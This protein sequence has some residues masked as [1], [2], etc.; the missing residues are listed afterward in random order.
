MLN[1]IKNINAKR[2]LIIVISTLFL[3]DIIILTSISFLRE[4]LPFLFFTIVPGILVIQIFRLNKLNFLKRSVLAV[5]TSVSLLIF[6]GLFLNCLYLILPEPLSLGP[7]L[8]SLNF[9][10]VIL[11]FLSY[12][13][14]KEDF[15]NF[16]LFNLDIK[17]KDKLVSPFIF[18][19]I[20]PFMAIFG[21]YLMNIANN[22]IILIAMLLLIP[23]Y[24]VVLIYLKDKI[25]DSV[26]PF[27]IFMIG[28]SLLLMR[29]LTSNHITGRDV[30]IE[31]YVFQ[32][33]LKNYY[34][35]L[36]AYNN[37]YNACLSITILPVI[38]KVLSNISSEYIFKL[39]F[40]LIGS[41]IPLSLYIIFQKYLDNRYAFC[42]SLLFV[43]QT[44]FILILDTVRQEIAF[45]F[46]FLAVWAFFGSDFN[47]SIK[48]AFFILFIISAMVSHYT[49]AYIA[50]VLIFPILLLPF[51]KSLF[52]VLKDGIKSKKDA[53][54]QRFVCF[55]NFDVIIIILILTAIWYIFAAKVQFEAGS[56]VIGSTVSSL[57]LNAGGSSIRN[58]AVLSILG[59]GI[60]S[61]P[62]FISVIVNNL[63]FVMIGIGLIF[64][65]KNYS[66]FKK[67]FGN[68]YLLGALISV[69]LLVL[70]VILPYVSNAYGPQRL[71]LQLAV[72]L[73]P[74][75][76]MG[77][78]KFA[79]LIKKP[80]YGIVIIL[81]L[82][83]SLFTCG[84][85]LQ[86]HF[87]G[88]PYSPFYEHNGDLRDEYYVYDQEVAAASWLNQY[89]VTD[90]GIQADATGYMRLM[91]G[92]GGTPILN[93]K[94]GGY[95]YLNY[96]NVNKHIIYLS[97]TNPRNINDFAFL[98]GKSK[99]YDNGG[100]E[101]WK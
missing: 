42:A 37:P 28:L 19:V 41:F 71:F 64:I 100:A 7:V 68:G 83:I 70:F 13:R 4:A 86:Y 34:W 1:E 27:A 96:V 79:K 21:T 66:E 73:A 50:L 53:A 45:L 98:A 12:Y 22:N 35:N 43:F 48:K 101:I 16:K 33:A 31:F 46:F 95:V 20:F 8:I 2:W 24:V 69:L 56:A 9:M 32:L 15:Q 47:K 87:Y 11:A 40:G 60:Q 39:F 67:K 5:G 36:L 75:F 44:Y 93:K 84:T 29:G 61:L 6:I 23:V 99:I 17:I 59:I 90:L 89:R 49:T 94:A 76:I 92:F 63:I 74:I 57:Q 72:F 65:I 85:Y 38:Y 58:N 78:L 26:Y 80:K 10:V 14:N 25:D 18:P 30:H 3:I 77:C 82:L 52:K 51:L 62:N 88:I 91:L 81:V 97:S 55:Q 54:N